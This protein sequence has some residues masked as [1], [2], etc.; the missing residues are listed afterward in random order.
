MP[1]ARHRGRA[2]SPH[3]LSGATLLAPPCVEPP[4]FRDLWG[5]YYI[6]MIDELL[7]QPPAPLFPGGWGMEPKVSTL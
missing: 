6:D 5:F 4:P 3:V 7:I 2:W 1:R